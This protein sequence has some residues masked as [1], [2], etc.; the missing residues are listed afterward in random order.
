MLARLCGWRF[1]LFMDTRSLSWQRWAQTNNRFGSG[2]H[3][4]GVRVGFGLSGVQCEFREWRT[5]DEGHRRVWDNDH[6]QVDGSKVYL[7]GLFNPCLEELISRFVEPY[8]VY[9]PY[10]LN[11]PTLKVPSL[12]LTVTIRSAHEYPT[13]IPL[14]LLTLSSHHCPKRIFLSLKA[15]V[16]HLRA[17][18]PLPSSSSTTTGQPPCI[19]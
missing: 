7:A 1:W 11:Q 9:G 16:T 15:R 2:R 8:F 19:T 3:S 10:L 12:R 4:D 17:A 18:N 14:P 13:P 6:I 5:G